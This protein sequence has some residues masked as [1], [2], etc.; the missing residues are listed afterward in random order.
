MAVVV[1]AA[2]LVVAVVVMAAAFVVAVVAALV[3]TFLEQDILHPPYFL[4]PKAYLP[5]VPGGA[6]TPHQPF[7]PTLV[8][9]HIGY[10]LPL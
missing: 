2:A 5:V 7:P 1:M 4:D 6:S 3:V 8:P 10:F 9:V